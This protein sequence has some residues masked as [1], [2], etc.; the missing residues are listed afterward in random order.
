ME[1]SG[2]FAQTYRG[3]GTDRAIVAGLLGMKPD[4][5][6]LALSLEIA[7]Q[8]KLEIE[9]IE[10]SLPN[11]HPNTARITSID[12]NSNIHSIQG[13]SIGGGNILIRNID[14][15]ELSFSGE[16]TTLLVTHIDQPG[17][18]A[19]VTDILAEQNVNIARF[20]SVRQNRHGQAVMTIEVDNE[21]S[22][23]IIF[24]IKN[25]ESVLKVVMIGAIES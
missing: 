3:H 7:K 10:T 24:A 15:Q 25:L 16:F 9:F 14:G 1:L 5:D 13:E 12:V 19:L 20:N 21:I 23:E 22:D 2:S 17:L 11:T 8:K 18:I 6:N 4:D